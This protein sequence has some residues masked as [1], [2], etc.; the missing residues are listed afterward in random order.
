[1]M[2]LPTKY[3]KCKD[4][5]DYPDGKNYS[6]SINLLFGGIAFQKCEFSL[7]IIGEASDR[8]C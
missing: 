3:D 8:R 2:D 1:M 4:T 7:D 6:V 5:W